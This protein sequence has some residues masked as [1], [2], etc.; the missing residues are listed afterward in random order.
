MIEFALI[1][2][3][4]LLVIL[5]GLHLGLLVVQQTRLTHAAQQA[6]VA[7]AETPGDCPLAVQT[8]EDVYGGTLDESDCQVA[9]ELIEVRVGHRSPGLLPFLPDF[10]SVTG[11]AALQ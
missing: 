3:V 1:L 9:D 5:G 11:R 10:V 4:Q 7:G 6:A 8:A 2:P